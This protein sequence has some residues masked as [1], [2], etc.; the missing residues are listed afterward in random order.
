MYGL[1]LWLMF[2]VISNVYVTNQ[3]AG[4]YPPEGI[5]SVSPSI[6]WHYS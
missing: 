5:R 1:V 3:R 2:E 6:P 4:L